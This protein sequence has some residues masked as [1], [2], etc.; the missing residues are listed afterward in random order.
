MSVESEIE[1]VETQVAYIQALK[2]IEEFC[3]EQ[4]SPQRGVVMSLTCPYCNH[5][6]AP[7]W[8]TL[9]PKTM[10]TGAAWQHS[11]N[12]LWTRDAEF[13]GPGR[14]DSTTMGPHYL[15]LRVDSMHE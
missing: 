1:D 10:L 6:I 15:R 7:Q 14:W 3:H 5:I 13:K 4:T 2:S 9:Y 12:I 8:Q 11:P